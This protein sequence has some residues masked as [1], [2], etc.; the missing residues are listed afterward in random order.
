MGVSPNQ[1]LERTHR[2]VTSFAFANAA[3]SR[4]AAQ[5]RC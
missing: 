1:S 4:R 5:L 3:P 2:D